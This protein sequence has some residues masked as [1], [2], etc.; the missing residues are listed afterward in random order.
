[1]RW[2]QQSL[3]RRILVALAFVVLF[4]MVTLACVAYMTQ[5]EALE[6]QFSAQ[7]NAAADSKRAQISAWVA[8]RESDVM[9]L[10]GNHFTRQHLATFLRAEAA[11]EEKVNAAEVL[12]ESLASL[13]RSRVDYNRIVIAS[14]TGEILI[15][16]TEQLVGQRIGNRATLEGTLAAGQAAVPDIYIQRI[17][18]NEK[19]D[20][21]EMC[22]GRVIRA[23]DDSP[24]AGAILGVLLVAADMSQ[25]VYHFLEDWPMGETGTAV[26]ALAESDGTRILNQ[27]RFDSAKP[28]ERFIPL[29]EPAIAKPAQLAAR[30]DEGTTLAI[31]HLGASVI[32]VYRFIPEMQWGLVLKM[33]TSEIFAP[34][35]ALLNQVL[36]IAIG[37]LFVTT[38]LAFPIARTLV[39]P[40]RELVNATRAVGNGNL[41]ISVPVERRDEIGLLA[42]SFRDMVHNVERHHQQLM[43]VNQMASD[44]LGARPCDEALYDLVQAACQ[45]TE[46]EGAAVI[47]DDYDC[48]N[49]LQWLSAA[50][51]STERSGSVARVDGGTALFTMRSGNA[52][53]VDLP[54]LL[55]TKPMDSPEMLTTP[56]WGQDRQLGSLLLYKRPAPQEGQSLDRTIDAASPASSCGSPLSSSLSLSDKETLAA[57]ANYAAVVIENARLV[58]QLQQWNNQLEQ[59][60]A[61]RTHELNAVNAQLTQLDEMKT[62]FIYNVSHELR[63]P[64]TNLKLQ[65]DLLRSNIDSPRRER[66]VTAI[67]KQVDIMAQLIGDML[68]LLQLEKMS[69]QVTLSMVDLNGIARDVALKYSEHLHERPVRLGLDLA[70]HPLIVAG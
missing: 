21:Y 37:V 45:L 9:F 16:P 44:I 27:V 32:T 53:S 51:A 36:L 23:P 4:A 42:R 7:L 68:D 15:S 25:S 13:Q 11:A 62:E 26:L 65:S 22:F 31:D 43:A 57:L 33:D 48:Q 49:G 14:P 69:A 5:R 39:N 54:A 66:Y 60:V 55:F 40:I 29:E 28:L 10:S 67:A 70:D 30:G 47:L 17:E 41:A 24:E 61:E 18:Y 3:H 8:E 35:R 46:A 6:K 12:H 64:I 50:T 56:I 63:N 19:L 2:L 38:L 34:L 59:R 58:M 1:M 20:L 52:Q